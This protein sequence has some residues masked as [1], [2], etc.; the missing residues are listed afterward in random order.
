VSSLFISQAST[1]NRKKYKKR[2]VPDDKFK[3]IQNAEQYL[4]PEFSFFELNKIVYAMKDNQ[5]AKEM[6]K[7]KSRL[8]K[9]IR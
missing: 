6:Q 8:F 9:Y 5:F 3:S 2:M 1:V 7:E 4:N